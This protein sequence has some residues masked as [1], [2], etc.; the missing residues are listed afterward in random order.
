MVIWK[1]S[2]NPGKKTARNQGNVTGLQDDFVWRLMIP[3]FRDF[4][5]SYYRETLEDIM[6][7]FLN[8]TASATCPF[9]SFIARTATWLPMLLVINTIS[10]FCMKR[11]CSI[12]A[13][14]AWCNL[15]FCRPMGWASEASNHQDLFLKSR[16]KDI[17][18]F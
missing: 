4:G 3:G 13:V 8:M 10:H 6:A 16:R 11:I 14:E 1:T 12:A 17:R 2:S 18:I 5:K 9:A 7:L 15:L